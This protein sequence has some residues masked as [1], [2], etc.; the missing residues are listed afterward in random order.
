MSHSQL[1]YGKP[2]H[3]PVGLEHKSIW[4]IKTFNSN[5]DDASNVQE[6]QLNE[7][8]ELRNDAYANSTIIRQEPKFFM[9]KKFIDKHLRLAKSCCLII[10]IFICF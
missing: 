7:L 3:L 4:A 1:I 6:L 2:C 9:I 5:L 8:E 10:L